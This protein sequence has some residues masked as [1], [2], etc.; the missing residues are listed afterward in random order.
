[1]SE[2]FINKV[3]ESGI[4]TIDLESYFPK[5]AIEVFDIKDFLFMGLILKE[6]DFR[7]SLKE[8]STE[9]FINKIVAVNC[10]ADAIIPMW[11][12][13]L[14]AAVLQPVAKK[15]IFGTK[16]EAIKKIQL[17]NIQTITTG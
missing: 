3:A 12:Y 6:K 17:Q 9:K 1:M 4:I 14:I 8:L 5:E 16:E 13:M 10:S 2:V 7:Q 11:A 15:V